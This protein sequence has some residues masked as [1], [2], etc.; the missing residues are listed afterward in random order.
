MENHR[1][2]LPG[3]LNQFGYLFGGQLLA[4]VDEV[5]W[6]AATLEHPGCRFLTV[7]MDRVE[8]KRPVRE[9]AIITL[10]ATLAHRGHTSVGYDVRVRRQEGEELFSTL[11]SLVHVDEAGV[12]KPLE[13]TLKETVPEGDTLE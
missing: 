3:H 1:L 4:W 5:A 12:K 6:I 2:I 11:V 9:G 10:V 7:G 13:P 8:F